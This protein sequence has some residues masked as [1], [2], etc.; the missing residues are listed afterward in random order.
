MTHISPFRRTYLAT[1][2]TFSESTMES[3]N[4]PRK[5]WK[6]HIFPESK[7]Q[8]RMGVE[9]T[10]DRAERPPSRF[11]DG[12]THRG[13]YTSICVDVFC[14]SGR[15]LSSVVM[16]VAKVAGCALH[17]LLSDL[18]PLIRLCVIPTGRGYRRLQ[19][20]AFRLHALLQRQQQ[21]LR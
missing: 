2:R 18:L 7:W 12:E 8:R 13:P 16:C 14:H 20:S 19:C 17:L 6:S 3:D 1:H 9:P 10:R 5:R 15:Y 21:H 4:F 11:E